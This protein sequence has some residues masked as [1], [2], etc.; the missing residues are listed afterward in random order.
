MAVVQISRIQHRRGLQQDL[1]NLASAE[2][3]WSVDEQRLFIGNGTL[4]EGAPTVGRTEVLTQ[5]TDILAL[6]GTYTYKGL[7]GGYTVQTGLDG[8]HPVQRALQS[9]LDE[10]V[11]VKDFGAIGDGSTDDTL[12]INRALQQIYNLSYNDAS[13]RVRRTIF[14]PA[15]VY[16]VSGTILI[17]PYAH[18]VGDGKESTIVRTSSGSVPVFKTIDSNFNGTGATQPR[19][20]NITGIQLRSTA[21]ASATT[22]SVMTIN[23]TNG[24]RLSDMAFKTDLGISNN[25]VFVT[26]SLGSTKNVT[27]DNCTF[28][29]AGSGVN[30]VVSGSGISSVKLVNNTFDYLSNVGYT[31]SDTVNGVTAIGNYFGNV[32]VAK[33]PGGSS[34]HVGIGDVYYTGGATGIQLGKLQYGLTTTNSLTAGTTTLKQVDVGS[35]TIDYQLSSGANYRAGRINYTATGSLCNYDDEYTETGSSIGA[36]LSM[37]SAGYLSCTIS[38]TATLKYNVKQYNS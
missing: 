34:G 23:S 35:G 31:I 16:Q 7:A 5:H 29:K 27:F 32:T 2:L 19:D 21:N 38:T 18:L 8:L 12:A 20:I 26:D 28:S 37:N 17:P 14:F 13:S 11:S 6:A 4:D 30:V 3:G 25:L 10:F 22:S 33:I 36:T 24:I 9:K 15:G 1:P